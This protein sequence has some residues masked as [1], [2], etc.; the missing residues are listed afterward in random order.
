MADKPLLDPGDIYSVMKRIEPD[1]DDPWIAAHAAGINPDPG[2]IFFTGDR[3][4]SRTCQL[5]D[6]DAHQIVGGVAGGT[7]LLIVEGEKP[8]QLVHVELRP[9]TY[10]VRPEYWEIE[11][12][13]CLAPETSDLRQRFQA[14]LDITAHLGTRGIVLIGGTVA[15]KIDWPPG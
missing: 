10:V 9:M 11:V 7:W 13:G 8:N 6:F 12:L 14:K 4:Q 2:D 15:E 5:M 1:W 3:N